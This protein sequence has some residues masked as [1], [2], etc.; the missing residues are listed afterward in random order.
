MIGDWVRCL[1]YAQVAHAERYG[2]VPQSSMA[3]EI[4]IATYERFKDHSKA[5]I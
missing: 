4:A 3:I 5:I 1:Q 2:E